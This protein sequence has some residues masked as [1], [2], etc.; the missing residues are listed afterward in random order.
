M[1]QYHAIIHFSHLFTRVGIRPIQCLGP[2]SGHDAA[3]RERGKYACGH[4]QALLHKI[5]D[6]A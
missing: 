3:V 6:L 4:C 2:V 1:G 5:G